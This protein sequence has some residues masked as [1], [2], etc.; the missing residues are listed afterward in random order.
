MANSREERSKP[1][2]FGYVNF[3]TLYKKKNNIKIPSRD[4]YLRTVAW[5]IKS[6]QVNRF[7]SFEKQT[8][9]PPAS[10]I[11]VESK[12]SHDGVL[13]FYFLDGG[14]GRRRKSIEDRVT[15]E[16]RERERLSVFRRKTENTHVGRYVETWHKFWR[17]ARRAVL[18]LGGHA[19]PRAIGLDSPNL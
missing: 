1:I 10:P 7:E 12:E 19:R 5:K 2:N 9:H 14:G 3:S 15:R 16:K 8:T 18:A 4:K 13:S 17:V 11:L 6:I